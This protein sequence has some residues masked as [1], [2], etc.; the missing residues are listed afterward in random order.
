MVACEGFHPILIYAHLPIS[1]D[2][3]SLKDNVYV[4]GFEQLVS[5]KSPDTGLAC[6]PTR[7]DDVAKGGREKA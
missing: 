5:I 6:S 4:G 2:F 1:P 7:C 3:L